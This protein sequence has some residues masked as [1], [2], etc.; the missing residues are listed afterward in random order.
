[1]IK[2]RNWVL[3][4]ELSLFSHRE[5]IDSA[6]FAISVLTKQNDI[7]PSER[8]SCYLPDRYRYI[9]SGGCDFFKLISW[10]LV[11]LTSDGRHVSDR[12]ALTDLNCRDP[13]KFNNVCKHGRLKSARGQSACVHRAPL[14]GPHLNRDHK[15]HVYQTPIGFINSPQI[16]TCE[17]F[18]MMYSLARAYLQI[19]NSISIQFISWFRINFNE[20]I[21]HSGSAFAFTRW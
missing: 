21:S 6:P 7:L 13:D 10:N 8:T 16:R 3:I 17:A 18:N 20:I 1:M 15:T 19:Y 11:Y 14:E 2:W 12:W 5:K 9:H 4:Q